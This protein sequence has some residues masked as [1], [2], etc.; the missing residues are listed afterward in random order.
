MSAVLICCR[1]Y[2]TNA[3]EF[4][5]ERPK[6]AR[7]ARHQRRFSKFLSFFDSKSLRLENRA[8]AVEVTNNLQHCLRL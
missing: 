2:M 4:K 1:E 3:A 7:Q 5:L 6:M 8:G